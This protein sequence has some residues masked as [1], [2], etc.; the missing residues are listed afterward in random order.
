MLGLISHGGQGII[1][2][3]AHYRLGMNDATV[4]TFETCAP[5]SA[6]CAGRPD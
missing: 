3:K 6:P 1:D 4:V 5:D 2:P